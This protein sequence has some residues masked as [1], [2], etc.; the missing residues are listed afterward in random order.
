MVD[1]ALVRGSTAVPEESPLQR[2]VPLEFVLE[3]EA[4][5]LVRELE[6]VQHLSRGLVDRERRRLV[7]VD[8]YGDSAVRVEPQEPFFFLLVAHDVDQRG[9]PGGPVGVGEFFQHDLDCL[10]VGRGHGDEVQAFGVF[11]LIGRFGDVH[12][13]RH[14]G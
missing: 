4:I 3:P 10:A 12:V 11:D 5:L 1:L 9:G 7:V 8:Q 2:L 6:Q 13:V 14:A